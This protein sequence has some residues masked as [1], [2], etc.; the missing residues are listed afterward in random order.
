MHKKPIAPTPAPVPRFAC[1]AVIPAARLALPPHKGRLATLEILRAPCAS[2]RIESA[3][4]PEPRHPLAAPDAAPYRLFRA[5][6]TAP[7]PAGGRPV[8]TLLD[9]N[10]AFDFLTPQMLEAVPDLAVIGIGQQTEAQ[11]DRLARARD[12]TFPAEGQTGLVPDAGYGNRPAGG[13]P[14]FLPL[15]LGPLRAAAEDGLVVDP[16]RRAIWGHSLGGLFVLNLMLQ[17]PRSFARFAAI[18]P[19]LWWNPERL[20]RVLARH[21]G[22]LGEGPARPEIYLGSGNRERRTGA[23]GPE[24]TD[25]PAEFHALA[26]RLEESG[27]VALSTQV[28]DGAVHIASLPSSLPTALRFAAA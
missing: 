15:L 26:R 5:I 19:S 12:L 23:G 28:Y 10:A 14:G 22:A 18:S 2:H 21:L 17:R 8:L 7:A 4:L 11:F 25:A 16:A 3:V 13:A 20:E 9:G 6:P 27:R 24:P 1:P